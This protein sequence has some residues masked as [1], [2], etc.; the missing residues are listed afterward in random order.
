M[1]QLTW[2]ELKSGLW[3]AKYFFELEKE[4]HSEHKAPGTWYG[5][6]ALRSPGF[7]GPHSCSQNRFWAPDYET[8]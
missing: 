6:Q 1:K 5:A 2:N 7:L 3:P 4:C 8:R